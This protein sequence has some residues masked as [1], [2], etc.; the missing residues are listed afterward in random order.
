[1]KVAHIITGLGVGGAEQQLR[2]MLRHLPARCDVFTLTAPGSVARGI[3][4]DGHRVTHLGMTGNLDMTVMPLLVHLLKGGR[5]DLV[6][7]HLYR[8]CLYGRLAARLAGIRAVVATEHS[9][10]DDTIEGRPLN[11]GV[12]AMYLASERLGCATVAVSD[13][14][15]Q[16]LRRWGVPAS[17]VHTVPNGIDARRFRF[18]PEVRAATRRRL[19]VPDEAFVVGGVGRLVPGKHFETLVRAVA[20]L[21]DARLLLAGDGPEREAL[22]G[23]AAALGALD[24][25]HL[26]GECDGTATPGGEP[27]QAIPDLLAAMDVFVSPSSEETFGLAV[28]EALASGLPALHV[29]CPAIDDLPSDEAPGAVR[30]GTGVPELTALLCRYRDAGPRRLPVPPVVERYD[31]ARSAERLMAV[32]R[33]ATGAPQLPAPAPAA[34]TPV[35]APASLTV[36]SR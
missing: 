12:R 5:Y 18:D 27:A 14:V 33:A 23:I 11:A 28:L 20:V 35:P 10:G 31:I 9:L 6:H 21:P 34:A 26:L 32:Y 8:A 3:L 29:T 22:Q 25:I 19:G 17:R 4:A 2:L 36:T 1:M 24:R 30:I 16:R 15:A 13:T 7:T